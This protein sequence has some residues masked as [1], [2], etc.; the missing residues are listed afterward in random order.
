MRNE[1]RSLV[2]LMEKWKV[3]VV[4][5]GLGYKAHATFITCKKITLLP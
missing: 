2:V 4:L 1:V 5:M 3:G